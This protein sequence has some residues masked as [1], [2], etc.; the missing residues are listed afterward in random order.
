MSGRSQ[1]G[2]LTWLL[3]LVGVPVAVWVAS[4][5]PVV[6]GVAVAVAAAAWYS[7]R[8]GARGGSPRSAAT[9]AERVQRLRD[10]LAFFSDYEHQFHEEISSGFVFGRDEHA[11]A[12]VERAVL[13]ESRREPTRFRGGSTGISFRITK[14]VSVR[15]SGFRGRS[16]PGVERPTI[17]EEGTFVVTDQRG[18]F[19]GQKESREFDWSKLLSYQV[20]EFTRDAQVLYL[21]VSG[22]QKVSGIGADER[23][24]TDL[25]QRVAFAV[26]LTT[27]RR[28]AFIRRIQ[29]ELTALT[30]QDPSAGP[31]S[32]P[33]TGLPPGSASGPTTGA[34]PE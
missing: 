30:A 34:V 23:A 31:A 18:M 14:R 33:T 32:G 29:D 17:V 22:R 6:A 2:C 5:F 3:V 26:A 8:R 25:E 4:D 19:I 10:E 11:I 20:V 24:M 9:T 21:P 27:G 15:Q 12:I 16:I 28:D 7:R 13:V 1:V